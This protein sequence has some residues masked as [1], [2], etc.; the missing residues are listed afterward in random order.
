MVV[1]E[2]FEG[3]CSQKTNNT[4]FNLIRTF[5]T[6]YRLV[7]L[8]DFEDFGSSKPTPLSQAKRGVV[9]KMTKK[10]KSPEPAVPAQTDPYA[11]LPAKMP[12]ITEDYKGWLQYQKQKWKIQRQARKRRR[13]LFGEKQ[14]DSSD[15]IGRPEERRD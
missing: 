12:S 8:V 13:Q 1:P 6:I 4:Q 5:K 2:T 11:S 15:A 9:T 7:R 14:I 3:H 10:R